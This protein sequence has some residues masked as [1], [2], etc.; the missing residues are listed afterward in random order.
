[1]H[2]AAYPYVILFVQ[3]FYYAITALWPLIHIK[4]FLQVTGP[5]HDI[6]LVKTVSLL[7]FADAILFLAAAAAKQISLPV[8]YFSCLTAILLSCVDIYYAASGVIRKI[9][10]ADALAEIVIIAMWCY[11]FLYDGHNYS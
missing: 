8:I 5:K 11:H 1:M 2:I 10:L 6:W 3:G 7:L 9:Y 4:S